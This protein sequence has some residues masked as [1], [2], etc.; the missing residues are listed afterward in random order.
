M[1]KSVE[2]PVKTYQILLI[3]TVKQ[4]VVERK[5]LFSTNNLKFLKEKLLELQKGYCEDEKPK[6]Q[7]MILKDERGSYL[8]MCAFSDADFSYIALLKKLFETGVNIEK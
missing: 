1:K 8:A 6:C 3:D 4:E 5:E 7:E 2:E